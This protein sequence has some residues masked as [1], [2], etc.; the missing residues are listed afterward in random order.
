MADTALNY[1]FTNFFPR[2]NFTYKI[3]KQSK[4]SVNYNGSTRQPTLQQI[5]PL[6]DNTDPMNIAVGNPDITQEFNHSFSAQANDY[7]ALSGRYLWANG[8]ISFVKDDISRSEK[9]NSIGAREYQY[10]N[11]NG[12]YNAWGYIGYGFR[13]QKWNLRM[14]VNGNTNT[15]HVNNIVNG[16]KNITDNN[17]YTGGIDFDY[18]GEK[19]KFEISLNPRV[20]YNDNRSTISTLTASYWTTTT[21]LEMSWELPM[22]FEIGSDINWYIRQKTV[23]FDGNNN[24]FKWNAYVSKKFAKNDQLELRA[25]VNDILNQNIGFNRFA[26][27]NYVTENNYN[28]IKRYGMLSLT[29]N[30]TKSGIGPAPQDAPVNKMN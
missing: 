24:V 28:T 22:K 26:Q 20:T 15:N 18:E 10:V 13:I 27:N 23:V 30:F 14:G 4:I 11:V 17:S 16:V 1:N 2:A 9:I 8:G 21:E 25:Y 12:N 7:R 19:E 6:R 3:S 29:W 5:Q